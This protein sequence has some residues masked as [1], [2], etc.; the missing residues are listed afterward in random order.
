MP[1]RP[2]GLI[3]HVKARIRFLHAPLVLK[4]IVCHESNA[5]QQGTEQANRETNQSDR[6]F[7][8]HQAA[9][10]DANETQGAHRKSVMLIAPPKSPS[11][12]PSFG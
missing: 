4:K 5:D 3:E 10:P 6:N 8:V 11:A 7:P 2:H 9:E 1:V 12:A